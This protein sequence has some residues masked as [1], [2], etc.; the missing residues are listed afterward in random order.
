MDIKEILRRVKD[1][2]KAIAPEANAFLYGSYARGDSGPDSDIDL[3]ILL[4]DYYEGKEFA[5]QNIRISDMTYNLSLEFNVDLAPLIL[6]SK[7]FYKRKTLFTINVMNE[8]IE[9]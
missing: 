4:P 6:L 8:G 5:R 9:L 3:L 2:L 7:M 1:S